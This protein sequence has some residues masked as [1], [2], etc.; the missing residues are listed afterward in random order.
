MWLSRHFSGGD[1]GE[2]LRRGH[3]RHEHMRESGLQQPGHREQ[4][5]GQRVLQQRVCGHTLQVWD[6][7]SSGMLLYS[8]G[9]TGTFL[10]L[11]ASSVSFRDVF[12]AWCS[13]RNQ[14]MGTVK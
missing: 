8:P 5:M 9:K 14:S 2:R 4:R 10:I 13:I 6:A 11:G 1:G 7:S 12:E 3:A